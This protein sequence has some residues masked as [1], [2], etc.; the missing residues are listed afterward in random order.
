[1]TRLRQGSQT[2]RDKATRGARQDKTRT[3]DKTKLCQ[4]RQDKAET[5]EPDKARQGQDKGHHAGGARQDKTRETDKTR[6]CQ[7]RHT[8][9]MVCIMLYHCIN[10]NRYTFDINT[11]LA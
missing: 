9:T 5:R 4:A 3:S 6:P 8:H 7:T 11:L 1:M 2:R 10:K